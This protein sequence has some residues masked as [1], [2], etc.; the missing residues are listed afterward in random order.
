MIYLVTI[1][2]YIIGLLSAYY[3]IISIIYGSIM[4]F[5]Y[6]TYVYY[7]VAIYLVGGLEDFLFFLNL[8]KNNPK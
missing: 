4:G 2:L 8:G 1:W 3:M 7:M 6:I 5:N